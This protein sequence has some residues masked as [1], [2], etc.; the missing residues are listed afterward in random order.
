VWVRL[1]ELATLENF[2]LA[3]LSVANPDRPHGYQIEYVH[4]KVPRL[5]HL[6]RLRTN[7]TVCVCVCVRVCRV[8]PRSQV[9]IVDGEWFTGGSANLV[10]LSMEKDHTELN[11]SVWTSPPPAAFSPTSSTSTRAVLTTSP[12]LP[13]RV[14][15]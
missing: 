13:L 12:P 2:V 10:D 7:I 11:I 3:G 1:A 6:D 8:V 4:S 5:V 9:A 14:T 15:R